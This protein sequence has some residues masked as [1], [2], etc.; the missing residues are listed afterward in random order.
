MGT[1]S[2]PERDSRSLSNGRDGIDEISG[3]LAEGPVGS[4]VADRVGLRLGLVD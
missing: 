2:T 3:G 4:G 1:G